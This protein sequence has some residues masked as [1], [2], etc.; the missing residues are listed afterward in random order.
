MG[1]YFQ[2]VPMV[3]VKTLGDASFNFVSAERV[4]GQ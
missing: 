4:R 3:G 2:D 1:T